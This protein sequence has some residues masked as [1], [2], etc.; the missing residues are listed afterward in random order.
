[1]TGADQCSKLK[2][3]QLWQET[4]DLLQDVYR[5]DFE[6][7][8]FPFLEGPAPTRPPPPPEPEHD[9]GGPRASL[10]PGQQRAT[11]AIGGR[12]KP[13]ALIHIPR[14]GGTTMEE[15]TK[16]ERLNAYKWGTLNTD[17]H[18]PNRTYINKKG[19][20]CWGQHVPP[21]TAVDFFKGRE[22]FCVLRNP[23]S[24]M[25]SEFGHRQAMYSDNTGPC[26]VENLNKRLIEWLQEIKGYKADG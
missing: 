6:L 26:T 14:T 24:R 11:T 9:D 7:L 13:I 8:G 4:R 12:V 3:D 25:I 22:T 17:L 20:R 19:S 18:R 2:K 16:G 1:M 21:T 23:Y 15:C 10:C 5:D